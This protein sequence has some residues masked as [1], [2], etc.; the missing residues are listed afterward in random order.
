MEGLPLLFVTCITFESLLTLSVND[1]RALRLAEII[2]DFRN[3]Q[4]YIAQIRAYPT[5]EEYVQPI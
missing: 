5:S 3:L 2:Q 1:V 4:H